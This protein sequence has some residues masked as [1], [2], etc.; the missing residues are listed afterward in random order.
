[1]FPTPLYVRNSN[2][3]T[4]RSHCTSCTTHIADSSLQHSCSLNCAAR[5]D[6]LAIFRQSPRHKMFTNWTVWNAFPF[7]KVMT[8]YQLTRRSRVLLQKLTV[9]Q[10]ANKFP[11]FYLPPK[12]HYHIHKIPPTVPTLSHTQC[13]LWHPIPLFNVP[14]S[15]NLSVVL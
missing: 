2:T 13:S 15:P 14:L 10:L 6:L 8:Y 5:A 3:L 11:A 1:M 4:T 12:V 9:S 7:C